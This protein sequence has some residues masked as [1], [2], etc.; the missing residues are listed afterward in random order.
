M[1]FAAGKGIMGQMTD[2]ST[3]G[4]VFKCGRGMNVLTI[5][6][7]SYVVATIDGSDDD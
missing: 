2:P 7:P 4:K 5:Y 3:N 1:T 6:R